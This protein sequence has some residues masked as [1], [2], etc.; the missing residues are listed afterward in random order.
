MTKKIEAKVELLKRR[1]ADIER[2]DFGAVV[3]CPSSEVEKLADVLEERF[4]RIFE[5]GH[6]IGNQLQSHVASMR[7][8]GRKREWALLRLSMPEVD[9]INKYADHIGFHL[10]ELK[11]DLKAAIAELEE[12][13][14]DQL[15]DVSGTRDEIKSETA[16]RNQEVFVVH[17]HD[18]GARESVARFLEKLGFKPIILHEQANLGRTIIEKVEAHSNVGFAI[19]LLT[20]DD[21]GRSSE[22]SALHPR[23]RQNVILELGYFIGKLGRRHVFALK[24][25]QVEIP[26]D[27]NGVVYQPYDDQGAW[28]LALA[29]ELQNVGYSID[30]NA[31]MR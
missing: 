5:P 1:I 14:L 2:F 9:R 16:V 12:D 3:S 28:Q 10:N 7:D 17:G 30:L 21:L 18:E 19:V 20:P 4:A 25:G 26:S 13:R 6:R 29:K 8:E 11:T 23:A 22:E 15:I 27:F 24:R 31:V